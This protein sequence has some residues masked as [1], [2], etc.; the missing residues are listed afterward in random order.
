MKNVLYITL[1][2]RQVV[3]YPGQQIAGYVTVNLKRPMEMIGIKLKLK[4]KGYC[5]WTESSGEYYGK[6]KILEYSQVL[7]GDMSNK[8]IHPAGRYLH[9]FRF[10]LDDVSPPSSFEGDGCY[11]RYY[12]KCSIHK[13]RIG[14]KI[15]DF[16]PWSEDLEDLEE[17]HKVKKPFIVNEL[18][19]VNNPK[20]LEGRGGDAHHDVGCCCWKAGTADI[21]ASIDRNGYCPGGIIFVNSTVKN[22]TTRNY[23]NI[24]VKL[25]QIVTKR[26]NSNNNNATSHE[27]THEVASLVGPQVLAGKEVSWDNQPLIIPAV[28][29]PTITNSKVISVHYKVQVVPKIKCAFDPTVNMYITMGTVPFTSLDGQ[30][31]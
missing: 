21:S 3:Y 10:T 26:A 23:K 15:N 30:E 17:D 4:G 22:Q 6:E 18:I 27:V 24:Q 25:V 1:I 13:S 7:Y 29:A 5:H 28:I 14:N 20:Y 11:I 9:K 12:L 8:V 31:T 19:D 2:N 16:V